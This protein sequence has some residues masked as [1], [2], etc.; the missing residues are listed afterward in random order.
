MWSAIRAKG[1]TGAEKWAFLLDADDALGLGV[2]SW[3]PDEV[4][5]DDL[6]AEV[7]ALV[8][9]RTEARAAKDWARADAIRDE[10]AS[11]GITVEDTPSG[12]KVK[13]KR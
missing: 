3:Q 4:A 2:A 10:L 13:L 6:D 12:I 11:R 9:E 7:A 8:S 1:L 5:L